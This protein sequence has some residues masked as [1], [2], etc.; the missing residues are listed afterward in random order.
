MEQKPVL[1]AGD[2]WSEMPTYNIL[3]SIE[4]AARILAERKLTSM[5]VITIITIAKDLLDL[6][7]RSEVEKE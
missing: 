6:I 7:A 5:D 4:V 3:V 1:I 2:I